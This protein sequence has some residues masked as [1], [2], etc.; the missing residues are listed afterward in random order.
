MR[1]SKVKTLRAFFI[2]SLNNK[3]WNSNFFNADIKKKTAGAKRLPRFLFVI[4]Y[5]V[6]VTP[7]RQM[8]LILSAFFMAPL[9][10]PGFAPD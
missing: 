8:S 3:I 1:P 5:P 7:P 10:P 4:P 2:Y 9:I 6:K